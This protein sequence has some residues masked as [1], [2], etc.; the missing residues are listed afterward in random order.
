MSICNSRADGRAFGGNSLLS[1]GSGL[2]LIIKLQMLSS[3]KYF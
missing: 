1:F 3:A 2:T